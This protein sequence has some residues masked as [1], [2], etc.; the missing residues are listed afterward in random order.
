MHT[1]NA[2]MTSKVTPLAKDEGEKVDKVVEAEGA[3]VSIQGYLER[4]CATLRLMVAV[5]MAHMNMK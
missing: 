1:S 5:S 3:A 2:M 4:S